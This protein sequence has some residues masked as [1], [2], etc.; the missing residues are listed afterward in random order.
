VKLVDF[1]VAK[2][3][4]GQ[5]ETQNGMFKGKARYAS[6]EQV[7][8]EP[9]DRR[10]DVFSSGV[11]LFEILTGQRVWGDMPEMQALI[12]LNE[13][14]WRGPRD[15][16]DVDPELDMICRRSMAMLP[17]HRF[18]TAA[19]MR[20]AIERRLDR[21]PRAATLRQ[22][23]EILSERFARD[24]A[25]LRLRIEEQIRI[26][27]NE[28]TASRAPLPDLAEDTGDPSPPQSQQPV[29]YTAPPPA[30]RSLGIPLAAALVAIAGVGA[31]SLALRPRVEPVSIALAAGRLHVDVVP[32]AGASAPP[33]VSSASAS[34]PRPAMTLAPPRYPIGAF[35]PPPNSSIVRPPP[36]FHDV[37]TEPRPKKPHVQID[38]QDPYKK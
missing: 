26:V 8:G 13:G 36:T 38:E 20:D 29:V 6:P 14:K 27:T 10:S 2:V 19:E 15:V 17:D 5:G 1:G 12:G 18:A 28:D 35:A 9:L 4:E 32:I 25:Q 22:V 16:A 34:A 21:M 33:P 23:G 3:D 31:G 11:I 24:R 37:D 30:R 7:R